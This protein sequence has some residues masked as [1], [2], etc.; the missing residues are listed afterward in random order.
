MKIRSLACVAVASALVLTGGIVSASAAVLPPR[1]PDVPESLW[2]SLMGPTPEEW[3]PKG[4]VVADSGFEAWRDSFSFFNYGLGADANVYLGYDQDANTYFNFTDSDLPAL[5]GADVGCTAIKNGRCIANPI[6]SLMASIFSFAIMGGHCYGMAGVASQLFN[7][8]TDRGNFT[9][10]YATFGMRLDEKVGREISIAWAKQFAWLKDPARK[11]EY[12]K[13]ARQAIEALR[14]GLRPGV[15]PYILTFFFEGGGHA[16]TPTAVTDRGSG[17]YDIVVYDNNFPLRERAFKVDTVANT[18]EYQVTTQPG[19]GDVIARGDATSENLQLVPVSTLKDKVP[20][21][22]CEETAAGRTWFL[23]YVAKGEPEIEVV[24]LDNEPIPGVID[25]QPTDFLAAP[26]LSIPKGVPFRAVVKNTGRA[27]AS[28]ELFAYPQAR[29]FSTKLTTQ[30]GATAVVEVQPNGVFRQV[31]DSRSFM[32]AIVDTARSDTTGLFTFVPQ[33]ASSRPGREATIQV[34]TDVRGV[35]EASV[36]NRPVR[37]FGS[38]RRV[39]R[40]GTD[41]SGDFGRS[42]S[43]V[44]RP[45]DR[46]RASIGSWT[47]DGANLKMEIIRADGKRERVAVTNDE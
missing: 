45:A 29:G 18:W 19:S 39:D 44:L 47:G 12:T 38:F 16:I 15:S 2:E 40:A 34:S 31:S 22:P 46:L 21:V 4:P 1:P 37:V 13:T 23:P 33:G 36:G 8:E 43:I 35:L 30:P 41:A 27:P 9:N 7:Q 11:T 17:K 26:S 5:F 14:E 24:G 6:A 25:V 20:C 10:S 42:R 32:R 3:A 28:T